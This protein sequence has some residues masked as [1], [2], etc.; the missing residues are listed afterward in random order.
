[1]LEIIIFNKKTINMKKTLLF[2][3]L[4]I[5]CISHDKLYCQA[6]YGNIDSIGVSPTITVKESNLDR[7]K[8][9]ITFHGFY[10][11]EYFENNINFKRIYIPG[12]GT[13]GKIGEAELPIIKKMIAVPEFSSANVTVNIKDSETLYNYNIY[14]NPSYIINESDDGIQFPYETFTINNDYYN[15]SVNNPSEH[16]LYSKD[17]Y[18]RSQKFIEIIFYPICYNPSAKTIEFAKE[19]EI[20]ISFNKSSGSI[21]KNTGIF[22]KIASSMFIN[23]ESNGISAI[24]NDLILKQ[25]KTTFINENIDNISSVNC[26]YLIIYDDIFNVNGL[27]HDEIKRLSQHRSF[28]NGFDV[29]AINIKDIL[30][31]NLFSTDSSEYINET[32]LKNFIKYMYEQNN[33]QNT[34][35]GK[36]GYVLLIGKPLSKSLA[37]TDDTKVPT[38]FSH[39]ISSSL[40]TH[41]VYDT[42]ICPSDYFLTCVSGNDD[43]GDLFIGR[44]S[45]NNDDELFN[46]VNKTINKEILYNP[47][48]LRNILYAEGRGSYA[49]NLRKTLKQI[50][51]GYKLNMVL[52]PALNNLTEAKDSIFR[53]INNGVNHFYFNTHGTPTS[54]DLGINIDTLRNRLENISMQGLCTSLSCGAVNFDSSFMSIGEF[55]TNYSPNKGFSSFI[56]ASRRTDFIFNISSNLPPSNFYDYLPYS[57]YH[58]YS[59]V[60]GEILLSTI[61]NTNSTDPYSKFNFNLLGDPAL[62]IMA[63]GIEIHNCVTLPDTAYIRTNITVKEN[64]CLIIPKNG[65]LYFTN[66]GSLLIDKK[67]TLIIGD[68]AK[69]KASANNNSYVKIYSNNFSIGRNVDIEN[70]GDL[71]LFS[72][73]FNNISTYYFNNVNFINTQLYLNNCITTIKNCKFINGSD[74]ISNNC[75]IVIQNNIFKQSGVVT[76]KTEKSLPNL[77]KSL[78]IN[79]SFSFINNF[80]YNIITNQQQISNTSNSA[81]YLN[82][83]PDYYISENFF[84]NC[85]EAIT[86]YNSGT[87]DNK[88]HNITKNNIEYCFIGSTLYNSYGIYNRNKVTNNNIGVRLLNNSCFY[89]NNYPINVEDDKQVLSFNKDKQLYASNGTF[90]LFFHYNNIVG[91]ENNNVWIYYDSDILSN[92][93][94]DV[95]NNHWGN[96]SQF[97]PNQV[98]NQ[99]RF[100]KWLPF[101]NG[102]VNGKLENNSIEETEF[103]NALDLINDGD[104]FSAKQELKAIIN[105]YPES[106]FASNAMKE[107]F[108]IENKCNNNYLNLKNYYKLDSTINSSENL[109]SLGGFLSARCDIKLGDYQS[110]IDWYEEQL[111]SNITY[112]D[113]IFAIIDLGDIYWNYQ[114]DSIN[115]SNLNFNI[116]SYEHTNSLENHQIKKQK[117]LSTLPKINHNILSVLKNDTI[118][119]IQDNNKI[120][121]IFPNP[122]RGNT[123]INYY[124]E[125]SSCS[126]LI[127]VDS[128]GNEIDKITLATNYNNGFK[129]IQFNTT[130]LKSGLYFVILNINNQVKDIKKLLIK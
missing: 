57:L 69:L 61:I 38:S 6:W 9:N 41:F 120:V 64:G 29:V 32:K 101:W 53:F 102:L 112:Q 45:V 67:G 19:L 108:R 83:I 8:F 27:P 104:Y 103:I 66:N 111:N 59:T 48:A 46:I 68:N 105:K 100:F 99:P 55:L 92:I 129:S 4:S 115:R 94:I 62:N 13:F 10:I 74:I 21:Q 14:P 11:T 12:C 93:A 49:P 23:Y 72:S 97:N 107:L 51:S 35:D 50:T 95:S 30:N 125:V 77:A 124:A 91:Y 52:N 119:N 18:F 76:Y 110:A 89:F 75:N 114:L 56:G 84:R 106:I 37:D 58:N 80:S 63:H 113:S 15:Q 85:L 71:Y 118:K 123:T 26:D 86:M 88:R 34:Y 122:T 25:G 90:P 24:E 20:T 117:L 121:S 127:V 36:L 87:I 96:N 109:I 130:N 98:F 40:F 43:I 22:N 44:F 54:W 28:Y 60:T 73:D 42:N 65:Q 78:I 47:N 5:L 39:N 116:L 17:G 128:N 16:Y 81:I 31:C 82:N 1:M 70:I 7:I 3:L 33:A 126:E 79:N 2:I